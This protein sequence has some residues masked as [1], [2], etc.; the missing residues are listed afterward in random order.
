MR[1][2]IA[3]EV[4]IDAT[5]EEVWEVLADLP[6]YCTWNPFIR[7]AAGEVVPGGR[8][9]LTMYPESGRPTTSRPTVVVSVPGAELRWA[10]HF[11]VRGLLDGEHFLRLS[12]GPGRTTRLEHGK[13]F[14]G[15]LV[16]FL[17]ERLAGTAR[18]ITAMNAALRTR[19]ESARTPR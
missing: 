19:V 17:G 7:Q 11:L 18:N 1:T 16:P 15:L 8:L 4:T 2:T 13:R 3:T 12:E 14:R 10:G 6:R 9:T 5:P